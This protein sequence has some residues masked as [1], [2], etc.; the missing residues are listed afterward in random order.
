MCIRNK[1]VMTAAILLVIS[2]SPILGT[3]NSSA[4]Q[5]IVS[6][7]VVDNHPSVVVAY[8]DHAPIVVQDDDDFENG[9][10]QGEGTSESPYS[11][12][13]F[14][15]NT[16]GIGVSIEKT[17]AYFKISNCLFVGEPTTTGIWLSKLE[18]G[19]VEDS[20]FISTHYGLFAE[21][22]SFSISSS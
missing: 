2:I 7:I 21:K 17:T 12:N 18:N 8:I 9:D 10:W 20:C 22:Y 4:T 11:I 6:D 13:G 5:P 14:K 1:I 19:I 16:S 3:I 15:F